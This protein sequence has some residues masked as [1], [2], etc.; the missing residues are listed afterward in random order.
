MQRPCQFPNTVLISSK[1][2]GFQIWVRKSV[3]N[4]TLFTSRFSTN[5]QNQTHVTFDFDS[6]S[7]KRYTRAVIMQMSCISETK[8]AEICEGIRADRD[9]IIKHNPIGTDEEVLLWMLLSCL[10]SFL[11][12]SDQETPCFTGVPDANTYRDAILFVLNGRRENSFD[13]EPHIYRMLG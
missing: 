7:S 2:L 13:P 5:G 8:F 10:I 4:S 9:L 3:Q 1:P 12:L 11:S 6:V